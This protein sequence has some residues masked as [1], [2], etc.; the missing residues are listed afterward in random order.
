M[1]WK[2][3]CQN[4]KTLS[5]RSQSS[6]H[7]SLQPLY[8]VYFQ[9][10]AASK[11]LMLQEEGRISHS[12]Q[13]PPVTAAAG[14]TSTLTMKAALWC[15]RWWYLFLFWCDGAQRFPAVLE[16]FSCFTS[17]PM[18]MY[19]CWRIKNIECIQSNFSL[20]GLTRW[21]QFRSTK[22]NDWSI[23]QVANRKENKLQSTLITD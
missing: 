7:P 21:F 4:I 19:W 23:N 20:C 3:S 15:C 18:T 14:R 5:E 9:Q 16:S 17:H 6:T 11:L 10:A 12:R 22:S 8:T 2:G 13:R 1:V